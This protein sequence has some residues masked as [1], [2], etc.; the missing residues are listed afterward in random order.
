MLSA[1]IESNCGADAPISYAWSDWDPYE[2]I[3]AADD[4]T[5]RALQ[6][7]SDHGM[8]AFVVGCLAWVICRCA[9]DPG[10]TL[11]RE[12]LEAF[13]VFLVGVDAAVPP[14]T[15][16]DDRWEGSRDGAVNIALA[17]FYTTAQSLDFG[18]AP[19]EAAFAA[20]IALHVLPDPRPFLRWQQE[21]LSRLQAF[22]P[23]TGGPAPGR[24]IPPQLLDPDARVD[25][26][27]ASR[28]SLAFLSSLDLAANRFLNPIAAE[29]RRCAQRLGQ[30][31]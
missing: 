25:P 8:L 13:C 31:A 14:E 11:P 6:A 21:I 26:A 2:A 28:L 3:A 18:S 5:I 19:A 10:Y 24:P 12:Y 29:I 27:R 15:Q 17:R 1:Y 9:D 16:E 7:V 22:C 30:G 23:R 4:D 20:Q